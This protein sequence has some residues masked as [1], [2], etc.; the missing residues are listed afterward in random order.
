MMRLVTITNQFIDKYG[1]QDKEFMFKHGRPCIIVI[2]LKF[3]GKRRDFA[4]PF[5]SN[6]SP[7]VPKWQYFALPPRPSTK[8]YHRH[9]IHYIK[10]F[11]IA[12]KYKQR[13][14][15]DN[16]PYYQNIQN[17]INTHEK[18]ITHNCQKY[19]NQYEDNGRPKYA[20]D[21]DFMIDLLN[22]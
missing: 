20:V 19:L 13:F 1:T 21:L 15:I 22:S 7:N 10:M 11:P 14:R 18:E 8:P 12:K 16:N 2:K 5:R 3:R 9:G 17:I 4:V 6:I